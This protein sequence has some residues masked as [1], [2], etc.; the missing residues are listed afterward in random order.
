MENKEANLW[1]QVSHSKGLRVLAV[2]SQDDGCI[3]S[4]QREEHSHWL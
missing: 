1:L 2:Y 3:H 4:R